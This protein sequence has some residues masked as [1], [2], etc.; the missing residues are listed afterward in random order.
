[1]Y[2]NTLMAMLLSNALIH[3]VAQT[4]LDREQRRI[5]TRIEELSTEEPLALSLSTRLRL[6]AT[7]DKHDTANASRILADVQRALVTDKTGRLQ[8]P[9]AADVAQTLLGRSER[10]ALQFAYELPALG[11]SRE[12]LDGRAAAYNIILDRLAASDFT[13]AMATARQALASGS[14]RLPLLRRILGQL[15]ANGRTQEASELFAAV[16][17]GFP[18]RRPTE[19]DVLSLIECTW[20]VLPVNSALAE[21]A[22]RRVI[23][24]VIDEQFNQDSQLTVTSVFSTGDGR[25][26]RTNSTRET[27]LF[28]IG[29]QLKVLS[30]DLYSR[31]RRDLGETVTETLDPLS[32]GQLKRAAVPRSTRYQPKAADP[33]LT[34]ASEEMHRLIADSRK[35]SYR[36]ALAV[37]QSTQ[38]PNAKMALF[39]LLLGRSDA[40]A[41]DQFTAATST[42]KAASGTIGSLAVGPL[43]QVLQFYRSKQD[44]EKEIEVLTL[45]A[46]KTMQFCK[47]DADRINSGG[48]ASQKPDTTSQCDPI[49]GRLECIKAYDSLAGELARHPEALRESIVRDNPSITARILLA[50][51]K[52]QL[53]AQSAANQAV[54]S[55][56]NTSGTSSSR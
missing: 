15:V 1:M 43:Q 36:D 31:Y 24:V 52:Q 40:E 32:E 2:Q 46:K 23:G 8:A 30:P 33:R 12:L 54:G 53:Q 4:T 42:I 47:C 35:R 10:D 17:G 26:T 51:L 55:D 19:Q 7:L 20:I 22:L 56:R 27:L 9:F 38:E 34:A 3:C 49:I 44:R 48:F 37:A 29:S 25:T 39:S 28:R 45:L 11:P 14:F 16:L 13:L 50:Q 5:A 18:S 41:S 21:E 6:A